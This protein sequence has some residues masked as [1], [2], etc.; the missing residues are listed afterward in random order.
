[1]LQEIDTNEVVFDQE[2][3]AADTVI[4][5]NYAKK[6]IIESNMTTDVKLYL[7]ETMFKKGN[8]ARP[9]LDGN[10]EFDGY[11]APDQ[12]SI[13]DKYIDFIQPYQHYVDY[14]KP[15]IGKINTNDP[16]HPIV[17]TTDTTTPKC[18]T[19]STTSEVVK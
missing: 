16:V 7:L 11:G 19:S 4:D 1:M 15:I 10:G 3:K 2:K 5:D 13:V 9:A 6:A 8:K 18:A 17:W 12:G 14:T